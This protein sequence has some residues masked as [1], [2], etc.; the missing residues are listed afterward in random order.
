MLQ[1]PFL[2]KRPPKTC[3]REVFGDAYCRDLIKKAKRIKDADLLA[4]MTAVTAT[5]IA[6]AYHRFLPALPD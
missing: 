6:R 4:T 5:T 1:H 2:R 3:G